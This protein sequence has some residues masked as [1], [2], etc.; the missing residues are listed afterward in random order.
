MKKIRKN[1]FETNSSS[2]HSIIISNDPGTHEKLYCTTDEDCDCNDDCNCEDCDCE[3]LSVH[4]YPDEFEWELDVHYDALTKASYIYT[5]AL[6]C[7]KKL[8]KNIL[9]RMRRVIK[10]E[11]GTDIKFCL[12]NEDDDMCYKKGYIDHQSEGTAN[13]VANNDENMR[14]FIFSRDSILI[15]D[16]DN[17]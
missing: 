14:R 7:N 8:Q 9:D 6:S 11:N 5:H 16:N 15:I 3:C 4:I 17:R 2:T 10:K 13:F 1:V 12:H